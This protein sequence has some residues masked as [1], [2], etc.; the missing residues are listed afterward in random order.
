VRARRAALTPAPS[1][2]IFSSQATEAEERNG[3]CRAF[4]ARRRS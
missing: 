3:L 4:G 1:E 2:A